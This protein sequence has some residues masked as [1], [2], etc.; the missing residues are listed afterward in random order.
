[1][2]AVILDGSVTIMVEFVLEKQLAEAVNEVRDA[3]ATVRADLPSEM[4][5]P[6]VT[7]ASTA[8]RV[9]MTYTVE[10]QN[11]TEAKLF[12]MQDL[13][14][15]VDDTVS[16]RLRAVPGVGAVKRMGGVT[17]EVLIELDPNKMSA[18]NVSALDVSRRLKQV[19]KEAP[20][21]RGDVSGA[22]QAVR[23]IATVETAQELA[24]LDLPLPDGRHLRLDQVAVIKEHG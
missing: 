2:T 1:V 19:Q 3:V 16:K 24:A 18:L 8:G 22:E 23:T 9:V 5:D 6:T 11:A 20:G 10:A 13:S 15:F 7:K 21:G 12:D 4:R 17:R 14:W